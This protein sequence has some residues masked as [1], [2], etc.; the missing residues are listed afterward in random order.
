[1]NKNQSL[2]NRYRP[3]SFQDVIGQEHIIDIL[4]AKIAKQDSK[5]HNYI[6]YGPRG[7]GKTSTA[8]LFAKAI[9]ATVLDANGIRSPEDPNVQAINNNSTLD[10]IEIDAASHTGVDNI[11]EEI[12]DK[13][14]YP[15]TMLKKK[16]YVIDEVHMLSTSAFN[17]L[18]KTI[19]EPKEYVIFILATTEIHKVPETIISRCQV[20]NFKKVS[21]R[22]I[23][24]HLAHIADKEW[25]PYDKEALGLIA[26]ISDG[27]VRDAVKYLDQVSILGTIDTHHTSKFL[28]VASEKMITNFLDI[29]KSGE[30]ESVFTQI[31]IIQ[32]AWV[33]L[34]NFAKQLLQY[35]D[36]NLMENVDTY[37][38]IS[39]VCSDILWQIKY[40][41]Y[42]AI[43]YKI[44]FNKFISW[45]QNKSVILNGANHN[46]E[47]TNL[48]DKAAI[49]EN[50]T[51]VIAR[52]DID[53]T[54]QDQKDE[55]MALSENKP[56]INENNNTPEQT[57]TT[58]NNLQTIKQQLLEKIDKRSLRD[59][60]KD[61]IQIE[62]IENNTVYMITISS[63][64][65][66]MLQKQE[67][68]QYI[69]KIL[70]EIIGNPIVSVVR[71]I[72]KDDYLKSII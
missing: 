49:Q 60:L 26:S 53:A 13:I 39:Q 35:I 63:I 29:I 36:K 71:F 14:Q 23:I 10:Y 66:I 24:E 16:V 3:Q 5:S 62:K 45:A 25:L 56:T 54:I 40:Y 8:R 7:T 47:Y 34:Y 33:D 11:R 38:A 18:L 1:M 67:N 61:N 17:A 32:D 37:L 12:I 28:S 64:T 68:I 4:Q 44:A 59:N 48:K 50:N 52:N 9:N 41:P 58:N 55:S 65:N 15:P 70:W 20:F 51:P 2:A 69:E 57:P 31:D 19:E 43:V 30:R 27:C 72:K 46:E 22:R 6:F 42:P 21:E